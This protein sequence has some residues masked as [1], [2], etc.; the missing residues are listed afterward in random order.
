MGTDGSGRE[1]PE[2]A[3]FFVHHYFYGLLPRGTSASFSPPFHLPFH[4][5][6]ACPNPQVVTSGE[7]FFKNRK[8][9]EPV[10]RFSLLG[11]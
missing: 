7:R 5:P 6:N 3:S 1:S 10:S 11:A 9:L 2:A 4:L 8:R